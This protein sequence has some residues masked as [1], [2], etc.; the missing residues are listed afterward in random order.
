MASPSP[1]RLPLLGCLGIWVLG[2]FLVTS[3]GDSTDS[4][5]KPGTSKGTI[6]ATCI[7][8]TNP[9]FI[10]IKDIMTEEAAKHGFAVIFLSGDQDPAKQANQ[11][12][13][14]IV[15]KV[16]AIAINPC[17]SKAIGPVI[18]DAND[19]GI[20]VFTFDIKCQAPGVEVVSHIATDN[21]QGG[22]LA[23]EAMIEAL[24]A[25]GGEIAI[26]D[27]KPAESCIMR[28]AGFKEVIEKHTAGRTAGKIEI[29]A[30][31]PGDGVKD[32]GFKAAEDALQSHPNLAGIF[33]INDPSGL[34]AVAA[35]EK[36]GKIDDV[37][38][39]AFDGQPEGKQAIKDGKIYA[40]PVQFPDQ[41]ARKTIQAIMAHRAGETVPKE[42]LIPAALYRQSD[43]LKD[44]E[45]K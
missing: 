23:G 37:V 12:K 5:S 39:I 3:C 24:D 15:Q 35:L 28:V 2:S 21:F 30:E 19:A 7:T 16:D 9:Y 11:V 42:E 27:Y 10:L 34:G 20:P 31:L 25:S 43:A 22:R 8:L 32:K 38:V 14:F 29:V 17:D 33:A 41:I 4:A 44:P 40:D 45:L 26:L 18:A 36:A 1:L 6:G 13:D